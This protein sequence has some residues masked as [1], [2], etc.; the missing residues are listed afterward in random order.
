MEVL[1]GPWADVALLLR[2]TF[3]RADGRWDG[4]WPLWLLLLLLFLSVCVLL[5]QLMA[6]LG[7][8]LRQGEA[9]SLLMSPNLS[10]CFIYDGTASSLKGHTHERAL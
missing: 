1:S 6:Y 4:L 2:Q 10:P 9:R 7:W 8:K 3:A 5:L